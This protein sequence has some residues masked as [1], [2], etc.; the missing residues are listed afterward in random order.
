MKLFFRSYG[1]GPPLIILHGLYGSSDNWISIARMVSEKYNVYLPDLRNHG[2]SPHSDEMNYDAMRDD[3]LE[4]AGDLNIKKF[5]LVGHSMGGKVAMSFALK[6]PDRLNGLVIADIS[7]F[8]NE[9]YGHKAYNQHKTILSA[10]SS[11]DLS[12]IRSRHE[13]DS[14]LIKKIDSEKIRGFILKNLQRSHSNRF[15]WKMNVTAVLKNIDRIMEGIERKDALNYE[16]TGFPVLFLKGSESDYISPDDYQ[17]IL[18]IFP[19]AEIIEIKNA[20]HWL[21]ADQPEAVARNIL[22]LSVVN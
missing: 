14:E 12:N 18:K 7:P 16:I 11:L 20:G 1:N 6:W 21:H 5:F 17:D 19:S 15:T 10:M 8:T 2:Q 22:N 9:T 13:A 4:L 3:L